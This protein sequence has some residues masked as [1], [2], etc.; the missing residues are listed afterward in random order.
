MA[1]ELAQPGV[2]VI[3]E[4]RTVSPTI[5]TPR[6]VPAIV[7]VGKQIVD[8]LVDSGSG[9]STINPQALI[10][11]PAFFIS[12]A[13]VGGPPA[14]Y[15]GLNGLILAVSL[16][17]GPTVSVTFADP[18]PAPGLT[19]AG[20]V[21][22]IQK[23]FTAAG[24]T[25]AVVDILG[26]GATQW[27]MRSVG[28]G[29]FQTIDIKSTTSAAVASA[30]G[31]GIG[32]KYQ[33]VTLYTQR[34]VTIP[35]ESF[36]DPRGNLDELA[37][38]NE[39]IRV[40]ITVGNN[41]FREALRDTAFLSSGEVYAVAATVEGSVDLTAIVYGGG[42]T[43]S[44]TLKINGILRTFTL[45]AVLSATAVLSQLNAALGAYG[46]T[47][48]LGAGTPNG[49]IFTHS[50]GAFGKSI[51]IVAGG[52]LHG[53]LGLVNQL[54]DG[55]SIQAID[56]GDGDQV[57]TLLEFAGVSPQNFSAPGT[58]A[59]LTG[60]VDV[61]VPGPLAGR[62]LIISDGGLNQTV[63]FDGVTTVIAQ[64]N[65]VMAPLAGGRITATL[66]GGNVLV[67]T[68]NRFG[69]DSFIDIVGGTALG[70]IAGDLGIAAGVTR[71]S[72]PSL[73]EPGDELWVDGAFVATIAEVSPGGNTDQLRMAAQLTVTSNFGRNFFIVAKNLPAVA[74]LRPE[75]DLIVDLY[76]N[77]QL[78]QEQ[79]RDI[80][81]APVAST[82]A[83]YLSYE[84]V[85]KDLTS[86]AKNPGLLRFD[87]TTQLDT[88]LSPINASNPLA[89]GLFFAL[90]NAPGIQVAGLGVDAVSADSPYGTVEAFT[91]AAE[92]LEAFEVYAIAPLTHDS[93][94]HQVFATHVSVMSEP[95][96]KGERIVLINPSI[97][98]TKLDTLVGSGTD[99]SSVGP[100]GLIFDTGIANLTA[101]VLNAGI[102]PVGTIP[103]S[104]GLFLDIASDALRYSIESISGSQVTIRTSLPAG[105]NDDGFYA[106]SDL[107]D[108]PLPSALVDEQ[109]S[110]KKRGASLVTVTG[111]DNNG[112]AE[113]LAA[114]ARAFGNR[115]VNQ[116]VP[117]KTAATIQG[118]E[119]LIEGFYV[120][121]AIAGMVG[122]NPP[123]QSFTN[124]PISGFTRIIG[125][126]DRFNRT[127]L[128]V[129]AG[130]GNWIVV[131]DA[132]GAALTSRMALT[133]DLT[134]VETRTD[135][136]TKVVDFTA[137]FL[138]TALKNF[139]GRFNITQG[140]L[141]SLSSVIQGT[142]G[143]L[144][145]SGVLIGANLNNVVQD[146]V[147]PD[148]VL[149]DITLD[150]PFP[151]N[152][153]RITLV[154]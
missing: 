70:L 112:T 146:E 92:Y 149:I 99:G 153:I 154:I 143:L 105:T 121:A 7:G 64:I 102:N 144:I 4:F 66:G 48:S 151:A 134:S 86:V 148:T 124:F 139:I 120:N 145:E 76:G 43:G 41:G 1:A 57:T 71:A 127:Q 82:G 69:T 45:N 53:T 26:D 67:L 29:P 109:F 130:G 47:A 89:L 84:A 142:L 114:I 22:Q 111:P 83:I 72:A 113:T 19:P 20:V 39:T 52:T 38:Q 36:P 59:V 91:R 13:A 24:V 44:V 2:E 32:K 137:K 103:T 55:E 46:V 94:V 9:S 128:N 104:A 27:E 33:G 136:I 34:R 23:A 110:V 10:S 42:L 90:I 25:A 116:I 30:F 18:A 131:Q 40:F 15:G 37:I 95:T 100:T 87:D 11:I 141:D 49:L 117:D 132:P 61:S 56:D 147:S 51:E 5:L 50:I 98:T 58:Q 16:N 140:F 152:Y 65:A 107:N 135:S 78:S 123:Q 12:A 62:T 21:A 73:A 60:S 6:L 80:T 68:H 129:M 108:P 3:Q 96:N 14:V 122:Q 35:M 75:P 28:V 88:A 133:T 106:T 126:N 97:P 63:T 77:V 115:R 17:S 74:V 118:A 150:V 93:S 138:R 79:L 54:V 8:F 81:G 31:I 125:S 101:L 119:Q 85:R